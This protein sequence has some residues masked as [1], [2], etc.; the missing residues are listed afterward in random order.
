MSL[1]PT[2]A[3]ADSRLSRRLAGARG[4]FGQVGLIALAIACYFGV[5]ALTQ[6][7]EAVA[8][9]NAERLVALQGTVALNV[10]D[11]VQN[12]IIE[13]ASLVTIANW[14]YIYGHWPLIGV[15]L[16]WLYLR[17][18]PQF[19]LLRNAMFASGAIGLVIF[20]LYPVAP[21]R[22]GILEMVDTVSERS[23]S[24]RTLQPPGLVNQYAALPS[25]H[26]GWNLLVGIALWNASR[27][28]ALRTFAVVMPILMGFAVVATANHYMIDVVA[29]GIVALVGLAIART[30]PD[31]L[32]AA[33]PSR[34]R[35]PVA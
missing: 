34:K 28:P 24:Y 12:A 32:F 15:T 1:R 29:G 35:R 4:V 18:R 22:L 20:A 25:L 7:G 13:H 26:F 23:T 33:L 8:E 14:I 16:V 21:P 27:N 11:A 17:A 19:R 9:Q 10:E 6:S 31:D 3:G 30:M 2:Q 5:R